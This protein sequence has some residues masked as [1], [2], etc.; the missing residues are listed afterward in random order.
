M[1]MSGIFDVPYVNVKKISGYRLT[2]KGRK[3]RYINVS[4]EKV[5][6]E[7]FQVESHKGLATVLSESGYQ[8]EG[9]GVLSCQWR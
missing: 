7:P 6:F 5:P 4:E 2:P 9:K 3:A 1:V 8:L